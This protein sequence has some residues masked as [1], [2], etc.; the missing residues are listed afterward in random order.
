MHIG[1]MTVSLF[2]LLSDAEKVYVF[3]I[4]LRFRKVIKSEELS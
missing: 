2:L 4:L 3:R 1:K